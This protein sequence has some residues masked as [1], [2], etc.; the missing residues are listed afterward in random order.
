[1]LG[2]LPIM[3]L[4]W[5]LILWSTRSKILG[6]QQREVISYFIMLSDVINDIWNFLSITSL[7]VLKQECH[8]VTSCSKNMNL[9]PRSLLPSVLWDIASKGLATLKT[10]I[11]AYI[12]MRKN[13][14]Y[15]EHW[16][17]MME[18]IQFP[19]YILSSKAMVV[20]VLKRRKIKLYFFLVF[21]P[22]F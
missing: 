4:L 18:Q 8:V 6:E 7:S 5:M 16:L 17:I 3:L 1:M 11:F 13:Y 14:I 12:C 9:L 20:I 15:Q 19:L 2:N 21:L 10:I 22:A